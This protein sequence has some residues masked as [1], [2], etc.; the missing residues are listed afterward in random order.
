MKTLRNKIETGFGN[1]GRWVFDN[2]FKT[3][4]LMCLVI[5]GFASQLPKITIDT[6]NEGFLHK[7]DPILKQYEAFREQFGRDEIILLSVKAPD[8]FDKDFLEKLNRFHDDLIDNVPFFDD[9]NSLINARNTYG[10]GDTL[11]VDDLFEEIPA[12]ESQMQKKKALAMDSTLYENFILSEDGSL[13]T[14]MIRTS[15]FSSDDMSEVDIMAGFEDTAPSQQKLDERQFLTDAENSQIVQAVKDIVEKYQAD[16]FQIYAA[17]SPMVVDAIKRA[18]QHDMQTFVKL[19]LITIA[20]VLFIL[21]RRISGVILPLVVVILTLVSTISTMA[22]TGTAIKLPTQILPLFLLAV[23]V[24]AAVHLLAIFYRHY[25]E[26]GDKRA[27]IGH[28]LGHSG[29]AVAMTSLTTAAGLFSF[30]TSEVAPIADLGRFAGGGVLLSLLY[31]LILLPSLIAITPM[32]PKKDTSTQ[33]RTQTMDKILNYLA[34]LSVNHSKAILGVAAGLLV[35]ALIGVSQIGFKHDPLTWLPEHWETRQATELLDVEMK[36]TGI[37]EVVVDTGEVNGLYEPRVMNALDKLHDRIEE[38]TQD[39]LFVGK[40][41]SVVDIL[42]E[43]NRALN[44]NNDDFYKV[45]QDRELIAQELLLFENSGS[46][47]LEDFVDSQFSMARFTIKTPWVDA[48]TNARF[49]EKV[50]KEF[51]SALSDSES[52]YVTGMGSLFA[53]V[54]DASIESTK[55][56]YVIAAVVIT[57]MMIAMLGSVKLG[58]ISMIPN[59][60]P[61]VIAMGLMGFLKM[62]LDQFTMLIG[63]ICVGLVVDDTIHF[64]HNFRRYHLQYNDVERAVRNTLLTTGR[65]ILVTT[66]VLSLGFFIFTAASME[67]LVRFGL[68]TGITII[69]AL[70]G[71]L[72]LAPALMKVIYERKNNKSISNTTNSVKEA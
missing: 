1:F 60:L 53:R 21:F 14:V 44:R 26:H 2:K 29:L 50:E 19:A 69:L 11:I 49:I 25:N 58:L 23:G 33:G 10:E 64:M 54:M 17:G 5:A 52:F 46:D 36:G 57:L 4:L 40:T 24:A 63:S 41:T 71:D 12:S 3:L 7:N 43:S 72:L 66:V 20:V 59:L 61:I 48:A 65:A 47:D 39:N 70:L 67:N 42:K 9:I 22:M 55:Q 56:S 18:M 32:K 37:L 51:N 31:T 6:S 13:T 35:V 16:D 8:I 28:S 62:P 34:T 30:S 38:I 68:I 27:A 45:P 15:A